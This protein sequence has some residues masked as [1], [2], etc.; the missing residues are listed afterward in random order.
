MKHKIAILAGL[1]PFATVAMGPVQAQ[2]I[3]VAPRVYAA[4]PPMYAPV[5]PPHQALAIVRAAGFS[6]LTQPALR[7]RRYVLLASDRAGGQVRVAVNAFNGR[8]VGVMPAY[9]PRFAYHPARP[10]VA[11]PMT[12]PAPRT[13]YGEPLPA[14]ELKDAPPPMHSSR[15][16]VN[17]PLPPAPAANPRVAN[18]PDI[19]GALPPRPA[20]TPLP[21]PRPR[22]QIATN[23]AAPAVETSPEAETTGSAATPAPQ[24]APAGRV[25]PTPRTA[26]SGKPA[27]TQL[28]PVAPLD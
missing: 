11:V 10:P 14:P 8:I 2:T 16:A 20:R 22:P 23:D 5:M 18:A 24:S 1:L 12:V 26:A 3:Y 6:P 27:D 21:L 25:V 19:T 28:V 4:P 13:R 9:D 7:G 15:D 17:A